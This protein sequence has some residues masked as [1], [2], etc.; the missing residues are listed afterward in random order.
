MGSVFGVKLESTEEKEI[1]ATEDQV[2]MEP[3]LDFPFLN[4]T[5]TVEYVGESKTLLLL[6][7][8]P[9]SGKSSLATAIS[10]KYPLKVAI[11]SA[12]E[13]IPQGEKPPFSREML[14]KAHTDC[15]QCVKD[16]CKEAYPIVIVDNTNASLLSVKNYSGIG[17]EFDYV[18]VL[19]VPQT[20]WILDAQ[21]LVKRS[22]RGFPLED[23]QRKL[24]KFQEPIYPL[25]YGWFVNKTDSETMRGT[26]ETFYERCLSKR[27]FREEFTKHLLPDA[28]GKTPDPENYFSTENYTVGPVMLHCTA[29]YSNY[30][31]VSQS[32]AYATQERVKADNG[33]AF[34]I[35]VIGLLVTPRSLGLRL[36]LDDEELLLWPQDEV[37][38]VA[39]GGAEETC[40]LAAGEKSGPC[41]DECIIT[42]LSPTCGTGSRAHFSLGSGP[43]VEAVQTG[44]DLE[45]IIKMEQEA[46]RM[47]R[48]HIVIALEDATAVGYGEGNW[49]VYFDEACSTEALFAGYF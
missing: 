13:H 5:K 11:C 46:V 12:E 42:H 25:F 34:T 4:D 41:D 33:K 10:E 15:Q 24:E 47:K 30:G 17:H 48:S 40:D 43:G 7:G 23:I 35:K 45:E 18:D 36:K 39:E 20:S 37:N 26:G 1:M 14:K 27:E 2:I 21:E 28:S 3:S 32:E 44:L 9:G 29:F 22:S 16:A 49:M 8:P 31:E 19:V 38:E 6:R